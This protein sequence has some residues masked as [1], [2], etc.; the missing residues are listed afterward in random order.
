MNVRVKI[1]L[2]DYQKRQNV[3]TAYI[4]KYVV[5]LVLKFRVLNI[6][7]KCFVKQNL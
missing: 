7:I 5:K 4:G 6:K 3:L 1:N 2:T